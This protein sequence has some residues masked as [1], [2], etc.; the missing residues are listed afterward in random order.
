MAVISSNIRPDFLS[1]QLRA[2]A[3][4]SY[5]QE[6]AR[7]TA[8]KGIYLG[9]LAGL[10]IAVAPIAEQVRVAAK[11]DELF[12]QIDEGERAL[13]RVRKLVE[14]YRQSVLKAAVTG[15][16]TREWREQHV[17]ELESGEALLTR[18]L[19]AR[20]QAW[21]QSEVAKMKGK[22]Q[23]PGNGAWINEYAAPPT[24][25]II[26]LPEL[27]INW[28][29]ASLGSLIVIG[30]QN[31]I[32][33]PQAKYGSGTPIIRIDDFQTDW[34][35]PLAEL[36]RVEATEEEGFTYGVKRADLIINRVNSVSHLGKCMLIPEDFI[37]ALFESNMMRCSV[38]DLISK[39][40]VVAYLNS[41]FGRRRST[42]NC[43]HAVNQASINQD[44]VAEIPIPL[45]PLAEQQIIAS[46]IRAEMSKL[47]DQT[48]DLSRL[49][50]ALRQSLLRSAFS[51]QLIP[52][53]PTDEPASVLLERIAAERVA[54]PKRAVGRAA[55]K[56]AR[57]KQTTSKAKA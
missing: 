46:A 52:Q 3:C 32:Y 1:Y 34:I 30:P 23:R 10:P 6:F 26:D 50:L 21:E 18:I 17:G 9:A 39:E 38:S 35:R 57:A 41:E 51:G 42:K 5:F 40:F 13:D 28:T 29:W 24:P 8:Q 55:G 54:S 49:S 53:D 37:G 44:D 20:R 45:P 7:G 27:P 15:E 19:E 22:K 31:G 16:L 47:P 43:K 25:D 33:I 14:R 48:G 56:P 2:P 11:I 12:S 36:R 4:Q